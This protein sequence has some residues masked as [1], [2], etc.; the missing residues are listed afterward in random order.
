MRLIKWTVLVLLFIPNELW[1]AYS[2]QGIVRTNYAVSFKSQA[3]ATWDGLMEIWLD[4]DKSGTT[5]SLCFGDQMTSP[6]HLYEILTT[7][8]LNTSEGAYVFRDGSRSATGDHAWGHDLT[9][10]DD[11]TCTNADVGSEIDW[12][13]GNV[14]YVPSG[15]VL[16]TYIDAAAE[17]DTLFL[18]SGTTVITTSTL[19]NKS[20]NIV[21]CGRAGFATVLVSPRT[22]TLI[23]CAT[24]S[25][26]AFLISADNVRLSNL[27]IDMTGTASLAVNTTN[28]LQGLVFDSMDAVVSC[29]G[30]AR[31]FSILGSTA[32]FRDLTFYI[33]STD[34]YASGI[35][36]NNDASTTQ[37]AI[38]DCYNVTGIVLGAATY[39]APCVCYND[40]N[41]TYTITANLSSSVFQALPGTPLD[42]AVSVSSSGGSNNAVVNCI[43]C[44]LDG[45]DYDV[46]QTGSNQANVGSSVLANGPNSTF[47][48]VTYR[49]AFAAGYG[50]FANDVTVTGDVSATS[51]TVGSGG[52]IIQAAGSSGPL[53]WTLSPSDTINP[54]ISSNETIEVAGVTWV[55]T[56]TFY[57]D[58]SFIPNTFN[59]AVVVLDSFTIHWD[60]VD[61]SD[62]ISSCA[63]TR[64]TTA[65]ERDEV[66]EYTTNL[67]TPGKQNIL[68][69][70]VTMSDD[71]FYRF[72][73]DVAYTAGGGYIRMFEVWAH[74]E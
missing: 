33:T 59:G 18:G 58:L 74:T 51:Y 3:D 70:D 7:S 27:S 31:G 13:G 40:T 60:G 44:N 14:T 30:V 57:F 72:E 73:A 69:G 47:G 9:T 15:S 62:Y 28:N 63:L 53:T 50:A 49:T 12:S 66:D 39:G 56:G 19:V 26:T 65:G 36:A 32:I 8:T 71:Y 11:F 46:Y 16:Q 6:V 34:S 23:S 10:V 2:T 64:Y 45:S 41:P 22:G 24:S 1:A 35:W 52:K 21:G 42:T 4:I 54:A 67:D 43:F 37:N 55:S 61:A 29:P 25:V 68:S 38:V 5:D 20:I 17:G 48:T